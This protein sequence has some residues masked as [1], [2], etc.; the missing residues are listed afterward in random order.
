MVLINAVH[1]N[2]TRSA[3]HL[4]RFLAPEAVTGMVFPLKSLLEDQLGADRITAEIIES[5]LLVKSLSWADSK[6]IRSKLVAENR[7]SVRT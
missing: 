3:F 4:K 5:Y 1:L 6:R 2:Q 7:S